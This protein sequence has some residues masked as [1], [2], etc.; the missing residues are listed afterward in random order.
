METAEL[1]R[2]AQRVIDA[3]NEQDVERVVAC[4]TE[5]LVYLDA[6]TRGPVRGRTAFAR[7]LSKLFAAWKMHWTIKEFHSF[8][9]RRGGAFLWRARLQ[10]AAGGE[11]VE[12]DGMDLGLLHGSLLARNEV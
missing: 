6:N 10:P 12:I 7:Y 8:A 2:L 3:W 11:T 9:D 4:Y 1:M 5:D